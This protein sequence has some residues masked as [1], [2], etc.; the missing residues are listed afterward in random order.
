MFASKVVISEE[1]M[2]KNKLNHHQEGRL[3]YKKL[4]E[5][6]RTGE[7]SKATT[8]MELA[9]MVGF[10]EKERRGATWVGNMV[11]RGYIKEYLTGT[12]RGRPQFEFHLTSIEPDYDKKRAVQ[13]RKE[14]ERKKKEG[15][16]A[17]QPVQQPVQRENT[18][19]VVEVGNM[20]ITIDGDVNHIG[21]IIQAIK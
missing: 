18:H 19:V 9:R 13:K 6:D 2:K 12:K 3:H 14:N 7:I 11:R 16:Q 20:T 21:K 15:E 1:T 8:R 10:G 4:Q 5:I 17:V